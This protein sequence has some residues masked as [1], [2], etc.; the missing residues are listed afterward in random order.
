MK[1]IKASSSTM[2][3]TD[4]S[5]L[6]IETLR[7][8]Y[9]MMVKIR[10]VEL[11]IEELYP[12]DE[13]KTPVHLCLGQEAVAVGVCANLN[14]ND[15]VLSNHRG[16][17]HYITKGG[18]LK[19]M[20][21]E[22]YCKRTGCSKGKGGS[23]HLVDTSVGLLGSSS[24]VGGCIP[25]ATGVALGYVMQKENRVSVAFFGDGAV[26]EG[27]F[28]ES[29][30]F[31][32]LKKLPVIFICENNFYSV[33][34]HQRIRQLKDDIYHRAECLSVPGYRVDGNN[35][36][37][38]YQIAKNVINDARKGKGPSLIECRT[39]RWRG[40][41]GPD[42][43]VAAGYRTQEEL[44]EWMAKCPVKNFELLLLERNVLTKGEIDTV[45]QE[46]QREIEEAFAFAQASPLP[47]EDELFT[48]LYH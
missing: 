3:D 17:G 33:G 12:K 35:V 11:K 20:I 14:K 38:V 24:I 29:L 44:D 42:S 41:V 32:A 46:I 1:S 10:R 21:A 31:A 8:L 19:A 43:D 18:D 26:D 13:M 16:H 40:H 23:M 48:D 15:S 47:S 34:S 25:I 4:I 2:L 9:R 28:Y 37:E 30:N 36:V 45:H 7:E 27:A 22:L 6:S 39:Y 5:D